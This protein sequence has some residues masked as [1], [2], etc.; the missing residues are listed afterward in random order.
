MT[1]NQRETRVYFEAVRRALLNVERAKTLEEAVRIAE[2][3]TGSIARLDTC[4]HAL[5][6][7]RP[8]VELCGSR[9]PEIGPSVVC[10]RPA[11]PAHVH[12]WQDPADGT[13]YVWKGTTS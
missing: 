12:V 9:C 1:K 5:G 6:V 4:L 8:D 10:E 11:G 2:H 3:A 7:G 13:R